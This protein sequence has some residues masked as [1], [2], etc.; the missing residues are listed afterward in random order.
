MFFRRFFDS[1]ASTPVGYEE[2]VY[3]LGD[4]EKLVAEVHRR[5][6]VFEKMTFF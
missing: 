2:A 3:R 6:T 5:C 1:G 4:E